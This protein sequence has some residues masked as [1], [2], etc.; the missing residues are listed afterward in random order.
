METDGRMDY[1]CMTFYE[2]HYLVVGTS[3][4][5]STME[6]YFTAF[7]FLFLEWDRI[8]NRSYILLC[9]LRL[10]QFDFSKP[11][12]H[13]CR[14][15]LTSLTTTPRKQLKV[16]TKVSEHRQVGAAINQSST[17]SRNYKN[18]NCLYRFDTANI[19][20]H[21]EQPPPSLLQIC[22]LQFQSKFGGWKIKHCLVM[23]EFDGP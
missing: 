3:W 8:C 11:P 4:S 18:Y 5:R 21:G 1:V 10:I 19:W 2:F 6:I 14:S 20:L 12:T 9:S 7:S 22:C 17:S 15:R 13:L 23:V 16:A